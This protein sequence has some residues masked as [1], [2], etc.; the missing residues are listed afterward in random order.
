MVKLVTMGARALRR[1]RPPTTHVATGA[2]S[3]CSAPTI[4]INAFA[5]EPPDRKLSGVFLIAAPF[6]GAGGWAGEDIKPSPEL[7]VSGSKNTSGGDSPE[8][9]TSFWDAV[10]RG[11]ATVK[12]ARRPPCGRARHPGLMIGAEKLSGSGMQTLV[13]SAIND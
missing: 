12:L 4:L 6:V 1:I 11:E 8:L 3:R 7:G 2:A 13:R 10:S 5:E 9:S